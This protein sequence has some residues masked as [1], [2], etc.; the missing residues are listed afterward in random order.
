MRGSTPTANRS[1]ATLPLHPAARDWPGG[2]QGRVEPAR[3]GRRHNRVL[4]GN[5]GRDD[6]S[7][8]GTGT[9]RGLYGEYPDF[10]RTACRLCRDWPPTNPNADAAYFKA[11]EMTD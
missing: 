8:N 7:L 9:I 6:A 4:V 2:G 3:G 1:S 10:Q 11:V 5:I